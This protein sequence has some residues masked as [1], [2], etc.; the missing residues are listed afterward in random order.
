MNI[1]APSQNLVNF[2]NILKL[3]G[4]YCKRLIIIKPLV[5]V[6]HGSTCGSSCSQDE[7]SVGVW[8]I[9]WCQYRTEAEMGAQ[10]WRSGA[11][12]RGNFVLTLFSCFRLWWNEIERSIKYWYKNECEALLQTATFW[13]RFHTSFLALHS[14]GVQCQHTQTKNQVVQSISTHSFDQGSGSGAYCIQVEFFGGYQ[15]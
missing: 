6:N 10:Q 1:T 7:Q 12:T 9:H 14:N 13:V 3:I 2:Y 15:P 4:S 5:V 8:K 11:E